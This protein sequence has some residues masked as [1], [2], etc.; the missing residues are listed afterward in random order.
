M[1][2]STVAYQSFTSEPNPA[3]GALGHT[4]PSAI[5]IVSQNFWI[6]QKKAPQSLPVYSPITVQL[7]HIQLHLAVKITPKNLWEFL[8]HFVKVIVR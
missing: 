5:N 6:P 1:S 8:Q 3:A 2:F 7:A 4:V